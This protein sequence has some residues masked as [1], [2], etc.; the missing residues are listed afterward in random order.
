M[1]DTFQKNRFARFQSWAIPATS[2]NTEHLITH[3]CPCSSEVPAL[4][5]P[6]R[7]LRFVTDARSQGGH[8]CV[9]SWGKRYSS[10]LPAAPLHV[11]VLCLSPGLGPP[12]CTASLGRKVVGKWPWTTQILK[13]S[14]FVVVS[15]EG[16]VQTSESQPLR[17][18]G[19]RQPTQDR[20]AQRWGQFVPH[21]AP[22]SGPSDL[23]F[24][25]PPSPPSWVA[26]RMVAVSQGPVL[27]MLQS[28]ARDTGLQASDFSPRMVKRI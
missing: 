26:S 23:P 25:H 6:G 14:C 3:R 24:S 18:A 10:S 28:L 12:T 20:N 8:A 13:C 7:V 5:H 16:D 1:T 21:Q 17:F 15:D 22:L 9:T 11:A 2:Q 4:L 27:S 19:V